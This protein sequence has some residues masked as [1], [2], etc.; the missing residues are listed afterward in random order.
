MVTKKTKIIFAAAVIVVFIAVAITGF[1]LTNP[2]QLLNPSPS[3]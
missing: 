1:Y 2:H 3:A